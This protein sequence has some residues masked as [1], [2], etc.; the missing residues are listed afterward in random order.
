[1]TAALYCRVPGNWFSDPSLCWFE[2]QSLVSGLLA[3]AA[4]GVAGVLL[5][6]QVQQA[7][8]HRED[9]IARKHR[10]SRLTLPLTLSAVSALTQNASDRIADE[11]EQYGPDGFEKTID[12]ITEG[13]APRAHFDPIVLPTSVTSSFERFVESLNRSEDI[14]HVAELMASTQIFI[15]R[16]NSFQIDGAGVKLGL[17]SLMLDAAKVKILNG[18]IFN[19]ARFVDDGRFGIVG[20]LS[21]DE[22]WDVIHGSA[23]SLVF[24]RKQPDVFFPGFSEQIQSYKKNAISPWIEKFEG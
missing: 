11:Y 22:A 5:W 8:D 14:R 24:S 19:Y 23:Q 3:L 18:S 7:N 2:W 16:F 1:M 10:A 20:T 21:H 13:R 15:S 17:E 4:A 9:E 12:A 6:K